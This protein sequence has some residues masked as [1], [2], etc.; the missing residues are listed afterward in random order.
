[1]TGSS[2]R[3]TPISNSCPATSG[4]RAAIFIQTV[5]RFPVPSK[6]MSRATSGGFFRACSIAA[7]AF[8]RSDPRSGWRPLTIKS[9]VNCRSS[10][11]CTLL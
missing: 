6:L 4:D 5:F 9:G 1:M 7:T 10:R 2:V 8:A 11:C 3:A